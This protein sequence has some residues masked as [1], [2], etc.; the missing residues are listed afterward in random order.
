MKD[1]EGSSTLAGTK[2]FLLNDFSELLGKIVVTKAR[3]N[4]IQLVIGVAQSPLTIKACNKLR[5]T[6]ILTSFWF[7]EDFRTIQSWQG[8]APS[9]DY[10]FTIQKNEFYQELQK[11]GVRNANYLPMAYSIYDHKKIEIGISEKEKFG[12]DISFV[13]AGYYNRQRSFIS[14]LD[15]N[16][17]IWGN[18]W[19]LGGIYDKVLQRKG[20]RV[21]TGDINKIFNS[22][23]INL[24]L[25]SSTY[26]EHI[27]PNGDFVNPRSFEIAGGENFQLVD[28]RNLMSELFYDD[29]IATYNSM[30]DLI[31]KIDIFLADP[32]K[33]EEFIFKSFK[34]AHFEHTYTHRM[35]EMLSYILQKEQLLNDLNP[36]IVDIIKLKEDLLQKGIT[37]GKYIDKLPKDKM[38]L[39]GL[40]KLI[41]DQ[42]KELDNDEAIVLMMYEFYRFAKR[43]K[44]I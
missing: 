2:S 34:R 19:P 14:I 39:E 23:K 8:I 18:N 13:G 10:F 9:V 12:S 29:E 32:K 43:K 35:F 4:D 42:N 3:E 37:I 17:K 22:S 7:V 41:Q 44:I 6:G 24:N 30:D 1:I 38:N 15:Y 5:E 36:E 20:K 26:I 16:F 28:N 21:S 11:L 27:N 31:I 40:V 33:R 25:H